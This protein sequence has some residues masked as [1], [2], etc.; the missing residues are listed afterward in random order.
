MSIYFGIF[1][2]TGRFDQ[3]RDAGYGIFRAGDGKEFTIGIAHEDWFWERLCLATGL[4]ECSGIRAME[5]RTRRE[6]LVEKLRIAFSRRSREEW[7]EIL[8]KADVPVAPVRSLNEV[9]ED[10]HVRFREMIYDI[11]LPSGEVLKQVRFPVRLSS[12]PERENRRPPELGEHTEEVLEGLGYSRED[13]DR[14]RKG[15]VV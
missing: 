6:E 11:P 9:A 15:G 8:T 10:P 7:V 12:M 2:G 14:F 1:F 4:E 5:R 13:I 3:D